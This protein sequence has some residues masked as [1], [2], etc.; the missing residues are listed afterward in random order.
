MKKNIQK[1]RAPLSKEELSRLSVDDF[2]RIK[3]SNE[4]KSLLREINE[5]RENM[6]V[7]RVKKIKNEALQLLSELKATG[8]SIHSVGDLIGMSSRYDKAIPILLRHLQLPYSD[9]IKATIARSLAVP[10]EEVRKA[11][12]ILVGEYR[13]APIGMGPIV[14]GDSAEFKL[15][16][17]DAL[18]CALS[19]AAT[20]ET[21][22][23]LI[24]LA[25]DPLHG[26]SRLLLLTALRKS[27]SP[28]AKQALGELATDSVL[29]KEIASWQKK[30]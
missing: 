29:K 21:L 28:M 24:E 12:P 20:D 25:K 15:G 22:P 19:V 7:A 4:E 27:K 23:E 3:L 9:A 1:A 10:E 5:E 6:R 30:P 14:Y 18:A 11:W 2:L 26:E 13:K 17:K 16:A 8:L